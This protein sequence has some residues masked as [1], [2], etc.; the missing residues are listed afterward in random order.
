MTRQVLPDKKKRFSCGLII[1]ALDRFSCAVYRGLRTGFFGWLFTGYDKASDL[2]RRSFSNALLAQDAGKTNRRTKAKRAVAGRI[3]NSL[4]IS[5][6][7]RLAT[8]L[9][10]T[11]LRVYA[12]FFLS[13]GVYTGLVYAIK[14]FAL[15]EDASAF[16][17]IATALLC[18]M[19]S[20]P[21]FASQD[22][23]GTAV[24]NSR[25]V[26][27]ILFDVLG[28]QR[29]Y[30]DKPEAPAGRRNI[31]LILAMLCGFAGY[32]VSPVYI[33]LA[34]AAAAAAYTVLLSPETGLMLIFFTLPF[35]TVIS[36]PTVILCVM[37]LAVAASYIIKVIRLKRV[38]HFELCDICV[39]AF[40]LLVF[41]GGV[42]SVGSSMSGAL[43][44]VCLM[45]GYFLTANLAADKRWLVKCLKALML[46]SLL[47]SLY[48]VYQ[49][50][51]GNVESKWLDEDMFEE[52]SG[53]IVSTF[54][55]PNVLGEYL[56]MM[57][58]LVLALLLLSKRASSGV[59]RFCCCGLLLAATMLTFARGAWLGL[60]FG[61]LL[62]FLILNRRTIIVL[63]FGAAAVPFLPALLP[64][65][66]V[67]RFTSIGNM[68][69]SS[70]SYRV[71]IWKASLGIIRDH[72][73][74]GIGVG[75]DAFSKVYGMYTLTGIESAP[76]SHN[77]FLQI[78]IELGA[79]GLIVFLVCIFFTFQAGLSFCSGKGDRG[80]RIITA[81]AM[82]GLLAV[83]VQGLTDYVWYN[84]RV[85]FIFWVMAG[86]I[87]AARRA[88]E[89]IPQ[90]SQCAAADKYSADI[91]IS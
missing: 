85:F 26:S 73:F 60:I 62:F 59:F 10:S 47:V 76:H 74:T 49:Y 51:S 42:V 83:L 69:D 72:F 84:Y 25:L 80:L 34:A 71:S 27:F 19:V 1:G 87:I 66:I 4:L 20:I 28:I 11:S 29:D 63:V 15:S 89:K 12:T 7:Q 36:H 5:A 9:R 77:L 31:S 65:S 45:L 46:S 67:E 38:M 40:M 64:Q 39:L 90:K 37:T 88:D 44:L 48:G 52:I 81:G 61:L 50:V 70:T 35:L 43:V 53:R 17:Y 6:V 79:V 82:S 78:T 86:I 58:P 16:A 22:S 30:F 23:L 8:V 18:I 57:I 55:N 56:I 75:E 24:K 3:E 14:R 91:E 54:E 21:L 13:F 32:F 33:L 2:H 68:A 41:F